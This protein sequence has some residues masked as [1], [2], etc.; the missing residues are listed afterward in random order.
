MSF[1]ISFENFWLNVYIRMASSTCS[2]GPFSWKMFSSP[3]LWGSIWIC[4]WGLF[5]VCSKKLDLVYV[6]R[7]L[8]SMFL[9]WHWV[10]WCWEI[11]KI[12]DSLLLFC[13]CCW[14]F[15]YGYVM[16]FFWVCCE[17]INFCVFLGWRFP[18]SNLY[19]AGLVERYCFNLVL[20]WTILVSPLMM[21]ES[22]AGYSSLGWHLCFLMVQMKSI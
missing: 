17:I 8:A 21:I 18:S 13:S 11:L 5:L 16:L 7:L 14:I 2:L 3:L 12:S 6:S 19:R 10:H 20:S 15:Y 22:F 1:P 9:L 4:H